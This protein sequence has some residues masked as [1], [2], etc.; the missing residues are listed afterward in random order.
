M[1]YMRP[2]YVGTDHTYE[3]SRIFAGVPIV[4]ED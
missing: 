3:L 1:S 4:N 2:A